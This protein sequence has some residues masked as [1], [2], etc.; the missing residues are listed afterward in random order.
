[1]KHIVFFTPSL[2]IGG[3]ERVF[4]TYAEALV[5]RGY[6]VT[7]LV[8]KKEGELI[9]LLPEPIHV[10]SLGE[11]QLRNSILPLIRFFRKNPIDVF[12]TGGDMPNVVAILASKM[13]FSKAKVI[14]SHHNYFNVERSTFLS[15]IFLR[16]IYNRANSVISVSQ[17]IS[18][19]LVS[20]GVSSKKLATIYNPVDLKAIRTLGDA[21]IKLALPENFLMFL[22]RLGEVKNLPFLLDAFMLVTSKLPSI[23]LVLVGEGPMKT[24]LEDKAS[25]MGLTEKIHFLG[26]LPNPFPIMRQAA[27]IMLPSFSEALPTIILESFAFNKTVIATP[28]NGAL[29]LL[30]NGRLGYVSN[31]F[32]DVKAFAELI[33]EGLTKPIPSDLLAA[34]SEQFDIHQKI[35]ELEQLFY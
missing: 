19:L 21:E 10:V 22:G 27:A 12:V 9:Q 13:A 4:I 26:V 3:V 16:F 18:K 14:I 33:V 30:E 32:D 34:K 29:D 35:N 28:T 7:Y 25:S 20:Q 23:H 5:K 2:Q 11:R 24:I 17:G 31:S 15:K 6:E 1:M 8:C